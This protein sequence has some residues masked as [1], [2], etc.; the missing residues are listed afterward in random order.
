MAG[1]D[2]GLAAVH[3]SVFKAHR[4]GWIN[5][6]MIGRAPMYDKGNSDLR[7]AAGV[8]TTRAHASLI[9]LEPLFWGLPAWRDR[10]C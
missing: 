2:K 4:R 7:P 3:W 5:P 8:A 6:G 9:D 1:R 10:P